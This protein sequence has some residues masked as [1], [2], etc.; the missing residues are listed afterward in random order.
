[1]DLE[2]AAEREVA[3][4]SHAHH[5]ASAQLGCGCPANIGLKRDVVYKTPGELETIAKNQH[6]A[7]KDAQL[8][9]FIAETISRGDPQ[10]CEIGPGDL[11]FRGETV[12]RDA[13][14]AVQPCLSTRVDRNHRLEA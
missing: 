5:V 14:V 2:S 8:D 6:A 13:D 10:I 7:T 1:M 9:D 4:H 12:V 11:H 3:V